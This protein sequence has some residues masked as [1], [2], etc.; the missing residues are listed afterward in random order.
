MVYEF[1]FK[2]RFQV[3]FMTNTRKFSEVLSENYRTVGTIGKILMILLDKK[4]P[5]LGR[6]LKKISNFT[7]SELIRKTV[8]DPLNVGT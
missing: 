5:L 7:K 3:N 8:I 4:K 2:S 1:N 6:T